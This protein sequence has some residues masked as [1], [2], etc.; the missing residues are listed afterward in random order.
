MGISPEVAALAGV[1]PGRSFHFVLNNMRLKDTRI[2]PRGFA[3]AAFDGEPVGASYADGQYWDDVVYPV[4]RDATRAEVTLYY[5]T[6]SREYVEFLRDEN[7]T[8]SAGGILYD[9][10]EQVDRSTPVAM[11]SLQIDRRPDVVRRCRQ[12]VAGLQRRYRTAY[13]RAWATCFSRTRPDPAR[14]TGVH[15]TPGWRRPPRHCA[16]ASGA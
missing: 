13:G 3:N 2:P 11:A 15:A 14:A 6:A 1:E 7:V 9:L 5:Q 8:T 12:V 10:W 4:G 16:I